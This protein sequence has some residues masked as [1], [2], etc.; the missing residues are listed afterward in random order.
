MPLYYSCVIDAG[1]IVNESGDRE[2]VS[3]WHKVANVLIERIEPRTRKSYE[4]EGYASSS[5]KA[6]KK[7]KSIHRARKFTLLGLISLQ[8]V[9]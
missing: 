7:R 1:A 6:C 8:S 2:S 5:I 9:F 3:K 4:H